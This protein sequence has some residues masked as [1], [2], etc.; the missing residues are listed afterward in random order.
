MADGDGVDV[1]VPGDDEG[2]DKDKD[3]KTV[4]A[5]TEKSLEEQLAEVKATLDQERTARFEAEA[6]A[7]AAGGR[8]AQ[9][10]E[11]LRKSHISTMG[12]AIEVLTQQREG[13]KANYAAA[14]AAGDF[15]KAAEINDASLEVISKINEIAKGKMIAETTQPAKPAATDTRPPP[16]ANAS[17]LDKTLH[18]WN[19][20]PRSE[21]WVRA[22]P[23]YASDPD[24]TMRMIGAHNIAI[25]KKLEPE[26][27]RYF[28]FIERYL[29]MAAKDEDGAVVSNGDAT[30]GKGADVVVS[31]AGKA[32]QTRQ[33]ATER[34]VQPPPAPAS[35]GG[36]NTRTVRLTPEQQDAAKISGLSNEEYARNLLAEKERNKPQVH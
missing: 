34:D 18:E 4:A 10:E 33:G 21:A 20:K 30:G 31:D 22:H 13:L 26:S 29:E 32:T 24:M 17:A 9:S 5:G 8:V 2:A 35:R 12:S 6:R 1:V 14:M 23:E 19:L 28:K 27:D 7:R 25:S 3:K 16:P 15:D 36:T 11:D